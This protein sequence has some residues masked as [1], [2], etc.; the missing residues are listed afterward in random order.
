MAWTTPRTWVAGELVTAAIGN[1]HW[2]DNF[3]ALYA[4]A[5]SISSQAAN[6]VP[7]ATSATQLGRSANLQFNGTDLAIGAASKVRLDGSFAGD[8]Y[9][10]QVSANSVEIVTGGAVAMQFNATSNVMAATAKLYLDGGGNTYIYE[11]SADVVDLYVGAVNTFKSSGTAVTIGPTVTL[12]LGAAFYQH[13][14][15]GS[16]GV[17]LQFKRTTATA[18][19]WEIR[20]DTDSAF[21]VLDLT[22][23]GMEAISIAIGTQLVTFGQGAAV[24]AAKKL[25]LDG[26]GDTYIWED[27]A[28]Q[29]SVVAGGTTALQTTATAVT[30]HVDVDCVTYAKLAVGGSPLGG[31]PFSPG[32]VKVGNDA[33]TVW[34]SEP[35]VWFKIKNRATGTIYAVPGYAQ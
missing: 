7:Y 20:C 14:L 10:H 21:K 31:T 29:L 8:T 25:Y 24:A 15:N 4:G 34:L 9:I 12:G 22:D 1:T 35:A 11:S 2:R 16:T 19:T 33:S 18:Q 3:N 17:G 30:A 26:G 5:M 27:S 6:D 32:T 23:A 13:V 28:N